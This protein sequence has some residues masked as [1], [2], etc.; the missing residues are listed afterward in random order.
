MAPDIAAPR[1]RGA[2]NPSVVAIG[3]AIGIMMAKV[4]QLEP[5]E[6][7]INAETIKISGASAGPGIVSPT[8][9]AT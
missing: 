2:E 5:T 3:M 7:A 4:P 6:N 8:T 1:K 9:P